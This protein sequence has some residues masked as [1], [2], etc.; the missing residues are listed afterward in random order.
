MS[1]DLKIVIEGDL[2]TLAKDAA[3]KV[4]QQGGPSLEVGGSC[5]Y[6]LESENGSS[7]TTIKRCII[8]WM[9][10]EEEAKQL[11]EYSKGHG[12]CSIEE[13]IYKNV[14]EF[15][16]LKEKLKTTS[17]VVR[18]IQSLQ[19]CHDMHRHLKGFSYMVA[20]VNETNNWINENR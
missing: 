12:G 4:M 10:S 20:F 1:K 7:D 11:E 15:P 9:M 17:E 18:V 2:V 14:L 5:V 19:N 6:H 13:L 8:G 3:L 16:N